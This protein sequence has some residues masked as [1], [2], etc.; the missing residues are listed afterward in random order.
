MKE[1][2][3]ESREALTYMSISHSMGR[4]EVLVRLRPIK[5]TKEAK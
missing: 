5:E 1:V 4:R 2:E 3:K